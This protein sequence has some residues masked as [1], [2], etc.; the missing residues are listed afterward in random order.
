MKKCAKYL[1]FLAIFVGVSYASEPLSPPKVSVNMDDVDDLYGVY[2]E[3]MGGF[4]FRNM[5]QGSVLSAEVDYQNLTLDPDVQTAWS[6]GEW[7]WAA[8]LDATYSLTPVFS[9][10]SGFMM[11]G[12]QAFRV[13]SG[14][15]ASSSTSFTLG[16]GSYASGSR[17][18]FSS[19]FMYSGIRG[20]WSIV[21]NWSAFLKL[22]L[23]YVA[24][25]IKIHRITDMTTLDSTT[26]A[27]HWAPV[28]T[29]GVNYAF[30]HRWR[31]S[32]GYWVLLSESHLSQDHLFSFRDSGSLSKIDMPVWQALIM[33]VGYRFAV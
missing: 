3:A 13:N 1:G 31:A 27:N 6:H 25:D 30:A 20:D 5:S 23:A 33:S 11:L 10:E 2:V 28:F 15:G 32:L 9:V 7:S 12:D 26:S 18:T 21:K 22:S 8:G 4:G 14:D 24:T 29:V 19:W 17:I 16:G